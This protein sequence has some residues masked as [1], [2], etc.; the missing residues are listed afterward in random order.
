[1]EI[2]VVKNAKKSDFSG[3]ISVLRFPTKIIEKKPDKKPI[4][5]N[6]NT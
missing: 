2:K 1:M 4:I 5:K 3:N 6:F